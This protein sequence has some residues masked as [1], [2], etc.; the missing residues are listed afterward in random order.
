MTQCKPIPG[1]CLA[2]F[3][4]A[5]AAP[6][7]GLG[8]DLS[9][10]PPETRRYQ[11]LLGDPTLGPKPEEQHLPIDIE[12]DEERAQ[13][14]VNQ[15]N[16]FEEYAHFRLTENALYTVE[17]GDGI[18]DM[19]DAEILEAIS[20]YEPAVDWEDG[21]Q[22]RYS[23]LRPKEELTVPD[24]GWPMVIYCPGT[25]AIGRQDIP[26]P[27]L[28]EN[29]PDRLPD[30]AIW[31]SD[32]IREYY[33]A[34]VVVMHPQGRTH[35][36]PDD[37]STQTTEVL[38]AYKGIIEHL[39]AT[40]AVNPRRVYVLGFSMGGTSTWQL[41]R[42]RPD[43]FA[44]GA[45]V[46]GRPLQ[47]VPPGPPIQEPLLDIPIWMFMGNEDTWSGSAR[48]IRTFHDLQDAGAEKVRF[49]EIQG[50]RHE[51]KPLSNLNM[52]H[53]LFEQEKPPP[54]PEIQ[55]VVRDGHM[56][57]RLDSIPGFHYQLQVRDSFP[58][59]AGD[60]QPVDGQQ[61]SG[62]GEIIR[63]EQELPGDTDSSFWRVL[64]E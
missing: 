17:N 59:T 52:V 48:Y 21:A 7:Y 50:M 18:S 34:F 6:L 40:E 43:L 64:V 32:Y 36:Y 35:T 60:W 23:L 62:N 57:I 55:P 53:W 16:P 47:P 2:L 38:E 46:A 63:F 10:P 51:S 27:N 3:C 31:G 20:R 11:N 39:M 19:T 14:T 61:A 25:G 56:E 41:L 4:T 30:E 28:A 13:E 8:T 22:A 45:P 42:Q 49:W 12:W 37:G 9:Y 15:G 5:T 44:A 54:R 29:Y 58:G 24:D 1:F 33:P 26:E